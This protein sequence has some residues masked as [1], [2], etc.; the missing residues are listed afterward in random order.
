MLE[1]NSLLIVRLQVHNLD[2]VVVLKCIATL[3]LSLTPQ[4]RAVTFVDLCVSF[5]E[6]TLIEVG[7]A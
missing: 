2:L 4:A 1:V 5:F 6:L 3:H 7:I